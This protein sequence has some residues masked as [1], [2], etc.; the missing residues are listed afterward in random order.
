M[1]GLYLNAL[2][3]A[4]PL[5]VGKRQVSENLISGST[6][7]L[8]Q[9]G[10]FV[11][12]KQIVLGEVTHPLP[13]MPAHLQD[14]DTRT[15]RML[16]LALDEIRDE[17]DRTIARF[18]RGRVAV[19]LGTSTSGMEEGEIA[20]SERLRTGAWPSTFSY[21]QQETGSAAEFLARYL[22]L[23][24]VA[25]VIA[26]A[27]SSSGKAMAAGR[28]LIETGVCDAAIV[29]GCDTLCRLTVNGFASLEAVS[30]GRCNPS[31]ANRDGIN[32][33]EG[34]ALFVMTPDPGTIGFYGAGETSDAY[35][36]SAPHPRGDGAKA[37][38]NAALQD[39][40]LAPEQI[41]YLNLHGTATEHNDRA[42]SHAVH[43]VF[44]PNLPCSSTKPMTG[45]M[46]G[47]AAGCE[48]AFL[49]LT[50]HP[51]FGDGRLPPHVWDGAID[52]EL[53]PLNLV[54]GGAS[55]LL[56]PGSAM[57]SNSFAFSGSNIALIL[58]RV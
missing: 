14:F 32:I 12:D 22:G 9:R 40:A 56:Q 48:T 33:G 35:H 42:E 18:G 53:S 50:L 37:A 13:D 4:T 46:L 11:N 19:V 26:T 27:C 45:H 58:G 43:D 36:I 5:G 52:P 28:R 6:A 7:G 55:T 39:A 3:I 10:D 51:E 57:L 49:W 29:G 41:A 47:A 17:V 54:P 8:S 21:A 2:G 20:F 34:A 30:K 38:M 25:Y 15:C 31:S 23:D 1:K 24:G 16:I 44:G